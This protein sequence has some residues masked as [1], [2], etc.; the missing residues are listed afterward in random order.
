MTSSC[1]TRRR[2][3]GPAPL[4]APWRDRARRSTRSRRGPAAAARWRI[5][6]R[7]FP[8]SPA[9]PCSAPASRISA[10]SCPSQSWSFQSPTPTLWLEFS[11]RPSSQLELGTFEAWHGTPRARG[12]GSAMPRWW[13]S[14]LGARR[15]DGRCYRRSGRSEQGTALQLLRRQEGAL[16]SRAGDRARALASAVRLTGAG[17]DDIGE[18]AGATF[19][20]HA[21]HPELGRLLQ[22]E[23]LQDGPP[24]EA[25]GRTS[26]L[27]RESGAFRRRPARRPTRQRPRSRPPRV[28]PDRPGRLVADRA[29][30][31]RDDHRSRSTTTSGTRPPTRVRRRGRTAPRVTVTH[32]TARIRQEPSSEE[33]AMRPGQPPQSTTA[34]I[35]WPP[36]GNRLDQG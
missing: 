33:A 29:A 28:R 16:G 24:A 6:C 10:G 25:V 2:G 7:C 26:A 30:A 22:W 35:A 1:T 13:S 4:A 21:T 5:R 3:R 20:Y 17:L 32:L 36:V 9:P 18:F 12:A 11:T 14:P 8:R 23:G 31:G 27:P 34:R 19:D 15:H